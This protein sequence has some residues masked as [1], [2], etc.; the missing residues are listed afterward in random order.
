M[1]EE[2]ARVLPILEAL[3]DDPRL[4][5]ALR[6]I[7]TR[8]AAVASVAVQ[9]G[10]HI[11]NDV[12]GLADPDMAGVA[13]R[14]RAGLVLGHMRGTPAT[15]MAETS[16]ARLF[17]DIAADLERSLERALRAG[18]AREAIVLDPCVG[19]GKDARPRGRG[20]RGAGRP[21]DAPGPGAR[22][23]GLLA[24][25]WCAAAGGSRLVPRVS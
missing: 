24:C 10:A 6:S 12:S 15:M 8:H 3:R 17:D 20:V 4:A 13:A 2:R 1:D 21:E 7:D 25:G 22:G 9:A 16:F 14:H 11:V 5:A 18:V 23:L 19:F